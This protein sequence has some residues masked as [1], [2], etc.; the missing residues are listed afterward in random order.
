MGCENKK[1]I[2]GKRRGEK[3]REVER[4]ERKQDNRMPSSA[5]YGGPVRRAQGPRS[6]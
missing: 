6:S 4:K 1:K 2:E 5:V 3:E